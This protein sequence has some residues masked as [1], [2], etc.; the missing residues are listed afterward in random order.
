MKQF[1]YTENKFL[2]ILFID[3]FLH[4]ENLIF[5]YR[6]PILYLLVALVQF[7]LPLRAQHATAHIHILM[8]SLVWWLAVP[9]M[10]SCPVTALPV[11]FSEACPTL[12]MD[13]STWLPSCEGSCVND[14]G[15]DP[16]VAPCELC[17]PA[18]AVAT[19]SRTDL[20]VFREVFSDWKCS[21]IEIFFRFSNICFSGQTTFFND[22]IFTSCKIFHIFLP[23]RAVCTAP[24]K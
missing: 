21:K 24:L 16:W 11:W 14:M 12:V 22:H 2:L 7:N 1:L 17:E 15:S 8:Q 3:K 20:E 6:L 4:I 9:T 10:S 18:T 5:I 19:A 13:I 23:Q